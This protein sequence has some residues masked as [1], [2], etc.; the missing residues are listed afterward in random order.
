MAAEPA[1]STGGLDKFFHFTKWGTTLPREVLAGLTSFIVMSYIIFVAPNILGLEGKGLPFAAALTS[2]CLVAG[3]MTLV[4]GIFTNRAFVIAP[5]LSILA[6]VTYSL[7]LGQG[8]TFPEA[9]GLVVLEGVVIAV[10]VLTGLREAIFKAIPL[11][12]KKA[13]VV[14][15]GFFILFIGLVDGG[16]VV[17]GSGTP[18]QLGNFV[19]VPVAVTL[20]GLI[21]TIIMMVRGWRFALILGIVFSTV[22]AVILNYAY[23]QTSFPAGTAVWPGSIFAAP[24][25]SIV[26]DFNFGAFSKLGVTA[27]VLWVF[28][29]LL[30]D[31]FDTMGTLVGVGGQ[32]GYLDE[33]GHL[34]KLNRMLFVDSLAAIFGGVASS[35]SGTVY[36]ESGAGVAAGGRTGLVAVV[37][38]VFFLLAMFL[39]PL[40]GIVPASA[41][42]P[43]LI[44]VGFLMMGTL[45]ADVEEAEDE[46]RGKGFV[47]RV[48]ASINFLDPA[49]GIPAVLTMTI[50]PLT[51]SVTNGIGFG[52][53]AY[54]LIRVVQGKA[55]EIS[56]MLWIATAGFLLYFLIPLFQ[57]WGWV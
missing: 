5:G 19:G 53:I 10:L 35:S 33:N 30:S 31:F 11:E 14:G 17:A 6:V 20:F 4:M 38:G 9:M 45:V 47:K 40:A 7:V 50:M 48:T 29:L 25:F 27:A 3:V 44:V 36:I 34:K 26:G 56:W 2:T 12:L 1:A 55:Q 49:F 13:I 8:L 39:S 18:V 52:F 41:T 24:D 23:G 54:T 46:E 16:I 28:S 42:A 43:A 15:I 51:Y 22:L 57:S 37:T 32:A 21:V